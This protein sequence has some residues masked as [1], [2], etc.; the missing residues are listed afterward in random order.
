M[1]TTQIVTYRVDD[2]TVARFEI[3]PLPGFVPAGATNDVVAFVRDAAG[4]AIDAAC[5]VLER[6]RRSRPD[7][8]EI[9][10]GVRVGGGPYWVI[11]PSPTEGSFE[12]VLSWRSPSALDSTTNGSVR[13]HST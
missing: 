13:G 4:P 6:A 10:F 3:E 1:A 5:A 11:A 9:R 2:E 12:V 8:V 7:S